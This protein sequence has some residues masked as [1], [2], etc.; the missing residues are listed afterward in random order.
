MLG[1]W[2]YGVAQTTALKSRTMKAKRSAKERAAA[3]P[4]ETV[5]QEASPNLG[6][7]LDL[8]LSALPAI[9]RAAIVLCDLEGRSI[10]R[11]GPSTRLP[12]EHSPAG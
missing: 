10:K 4:I 7:W 12:K 3:R 2:L 6:D 11:R 8:E 5:S 1:N 9:Y